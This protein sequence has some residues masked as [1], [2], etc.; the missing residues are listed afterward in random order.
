MTDEK[1]QKMISTRVE[2]DNIASIDKLAR[3]QGITRS[4]WIRR[5]ILAQLVMD[6]V[7]LRKEVEEE[8]PRETPEV[9]HVDLQTGVDVPVV[10]VAALTHHIDCIKSIDH[11]GPCLDAPA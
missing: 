4:Q 3:S 7:D 10:T 11:E 5:A 6:L 8:V 1:L 2:E 9:T